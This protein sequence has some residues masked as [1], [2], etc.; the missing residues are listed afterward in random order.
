MMDDPTR[1]RRVCRLFFPVRVAGMNESVVSPLA[2]T[3]QL[4]DLPHERFRSLHVR[5]RPYPGMTLR[6]RHSIRWTVL[7]TA[8]RGYQ[9]LPTPVL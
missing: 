9:R 8:D 3:L 6:V 7:G 4:A 5:E 1:L 2:G